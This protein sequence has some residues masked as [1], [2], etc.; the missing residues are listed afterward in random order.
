MFYMRQILLAVTCI[1][2]MLFSPSFIFNAKAQEPAKKLPTDNE[3]LALVNK[4]VHTPVKKTVTANGDVF[5]QRDLTAYLSSNV[6]KAPPVK[7]AEADHGH[8]HK[9]DMLRTFLNRPQPSV[10]TM[11]K[12]FREAATEF[13]VP[14]SILKASA[15]V[16][17][18]WAQVS[19]SIYGSWGVMGLIENRFTQQI[20]KAASLL[21]VDANDIKSDARTNIRAAA[22]LLAHYQKGKP[23]T[24][25]V[26]DWFE[27]VKD[28]TGLW[29]ESLANGLALRI[30]D[31]MKSGSKTVT[32][33]GEIIFIESAK[34]ALSKSV[35]DRGAVETNTQRT[36]I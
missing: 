36:Q 34:V 19:E 23:A 32:L 17:S 16:Q 13:G 4:Y 12:Y 3:L 6:F 8:D 20:T 7:A 1:L 18:N 10:A 5:L 22:A 11:E 33:W 26:E 28:L 29:D 21:G 14:E 15:Q 2:G 9:D 25:S 31:V 30:Y 35:S 27:S 24:T